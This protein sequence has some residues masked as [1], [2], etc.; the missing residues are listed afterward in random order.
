[1][2]T[3]GGSQTAFE[4]VVF[5]DA[6]L[7]NILKSGKKMISEGMNQIADATLA[8]VVEESQKRPDGKSAVDQGFLHNSGNWQTKKEG[9]W[10]RRIISLVEHAVYVQEGTKPRTEMNP[11]PW[12]PIAAWAERHH[13]PPFPIWHSIAHKGTKANPFATRAIDWMKQ[14]DLAGFL[15]GGLTNG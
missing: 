12:G 7:Q 1:M 13:L 3:V 5:T 2:A 8:K 11:P 9:E 15:K 10:N 4:V 14:Q 6:E